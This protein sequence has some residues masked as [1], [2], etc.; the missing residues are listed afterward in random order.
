MKTH[1]KLAVLAAVLAA[2]AAVSISTLVSSGDL[3]ADLTGGSCPAEYKAGSYVAGLSVTFNGR[4]YTCNTGKDWLCSQVNPDGIN[5]AGGSQSAEGWQGTV[6]V[7]GETCSTTNAP[8]S[9]TVTGD[10]SVAG[11]TT[12][13]SLDVNGTA[14]LDSVQAD[15]LSIAGAAIVPANLVT[16]QTVAQTVEDAISDITLPD[17]TSYVQDTELTSAISAL[18]NVYITDSDLQTAI[19]AIPAFSGVTQSQLDT[20]IGGLDATYAKDADVSALSE[21]VL[22]KENPLISG[23]VTLKSPIGETG[24]LEVSDV[25]VNSQQTTPYTYLTQVLTKS[26]DRFKWI[27]AGTETLDMSERSLNVNGVISAKGRIA[28]SELNPGVGGQYVTQVSNEQI[29]T[30]TTKVLKVTHELPDSGIFNIISGTASLLRLNPSLNS[31]STSLDIV[32]SRNF[33]ADLDASI[34]RN[35]SV[36]GDLAVSGNVRGSTIQ[37]TCNPNAAC[38][39]INNLFQV[40]TVLSATRGVTAIQCAAL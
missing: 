10:L 24:T 3:K 27:V 34:G 1:A 32:T 36:T 23:K 5:T 14:T 22:P 12:T 26:G 6:W 31:L 9:Q 25:K 8:I 4:I 30:G 37:V 21:T 17:L 7:P 33:R 15:S 40:G 19:A 11:K 13:S 2:G 28:I 16:T 29:G 18:A 38:T 35:L 39:C 20:A